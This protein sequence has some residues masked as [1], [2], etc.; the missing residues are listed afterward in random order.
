MPR[1]AAAGAI[2]AAI[3]RAITPLPGVFSTPQWGG[4]AYKVPG[5]GNSKKRPKLLAFIEQPRDRKAVIVSFKLPKPRAAAAIRQHAWIKRNSFGSLG[6]S[7]WVEAHITAARHITTLAPLIRE[8]RTL[9]PTFANDAEPRTTR[10]TRPAHDARQ[11][12]NDSKRRADGPPSS[13]PSPSKGEG[14]EGVAAANQ[15]GA[16]HADPLARHI[17]RVL[18]AA[19]AGGWS[20]VDDP[21]TPAPEARRPRSGTLSLRERAG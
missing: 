5:P 17:A 19:K 1:T 14:R 6:R 7:G 12:A 2:L 15:P 18:E 16:P 11:R 21:T 20:P 9:L 13:S 3:D 10:D 4:R 8:S